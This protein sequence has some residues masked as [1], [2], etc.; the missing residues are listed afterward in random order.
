M[1]NRTQ[2]RLDRAEA[3][4]DALAVCESPDDFSMVLVN[5]IFQKEELIFAF[6]FDVEGTSELRRIGGFGDPFVAQF[7]AR[8][9]TW[10][11][12]VVAHSYRDDVIVRV[13]DN[14]TYRQKYSST[15]FAGPAQGIICLPLHH[16][17]K[18][19]GA[20]SLIFRHALSLHDIDN[21]EIRLVQQCGEHLLRDWRLRAVTDAPETRGQ[22]PALTQRQTTILEKMR[23]G[24]SLGEIGIEL[25]VSQAT[26]K[27]DVQKIYRALGVHKKRDAIRVG[28]RIGLVSDAPGS[29]R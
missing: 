26:V 15:M 28:I 22:P 4:I 14:Y 13:E 18:A 1:I 7:P 5:R 19:M 16:F 3:L 2:R 10:D 11:N 8:V 25:S 20:I 29:E 6:V 9:S 24:S 21:D 12:I 27:G 17:G 23:T